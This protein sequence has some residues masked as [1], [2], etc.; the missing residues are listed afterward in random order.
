MPFF[1]PVESTFY[2]HCVERLLTSTELAP[3]LAD[4]I[5]EIGPGTARP[6][7]EALRR[8]GSRVP[9]TG[10]ELDADAAQIASRA[11]ARAALPNYTVIEGDFFT[12]TATAT[13]TGDPGTRRGGP[14]K[15]ADAPSAGSAGGP[16]G[17]ERGAPARRARCA[18]GNPPYLP[19]IVRP[20]GASHLWGGHDGA[21]VARRVLSQGMD[22]VL[23]MI[24][25]ISDPVGLVQ[26]AR[27]A[28]YRVADW[29]VRPI[30]FGRYCRQPWVSRRIGELAR[31]GRAFFG[32]EGYLLAGVT[33]VHA[34]GPADA[35][36]DC[37]H[38][39][40]VLRRVLTSAGSATH[41]GESAS[42]GEI[43]GAGEIVGPDRQRI[44]IVSGQGELRGRSASD[45][46]GSGR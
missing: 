38:A 3:L 37:D 12:A 29:S 1:D 24:A 15:A 34:G 39:G 46:S 35:G 28:G 19:A 17:A 13:A 22:V 14:R 11:A 40:A 4:G 43:A 33:W 23:L 18:I 27:A 9:I 26:H 25:S 7:V 10:Y 30:S 42:V 8:S 2:G 44:R 6:V 32:P 36:N 45:L 20:V 31:S 16:V 21:H 41:V 5:V